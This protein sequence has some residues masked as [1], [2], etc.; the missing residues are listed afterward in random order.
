MPNETIEPAAAP[1]ADPKALLLGIA[2]DRTG[3]PQDMLGLDLNMEADLGI[4]SIKRVEILGAFRKTLPAAVGDALAGRMDD[5]SKAKTLQGILD[6]VASAATA[7]GGAARPFDQAGEGHEQA[8][9][10]LSRSP[11][12]APSDAPA[13]AAAAPLAAPLARYV[14][15]PHAEPLPSGGAGMVPGG[16]YIIV[17]DRLGVAAA[18]GARLE[19]DGARVR[20]VP[21]AVM[22]D[23]D[24]LGKWLGTVRF[25][26]RIRAVVD[27]RPLRRPDPADQADLAAWGRAMTADVKQLFPILRLT[28]PDLMNGGIVLVGSGMGGNFARDVLADPR[29][30][31]LFPGSGGAVGLIKCLSLEWTEC[32]CKAVDLD[33]DLGADQLSEQLHGELA[34]PGGRRDVGYPGG[35]RTVFR[36]EPA[37]LIPQ[38]RPI[39]A[40]DKD[41]VVL[42]IGGARGITAET[43]RPFA[44]AGATC[45][46]VGRSAAAPPAEDPA[47]AALADTPAL[48][49]HFLAEA[50]A[51]GERPRPAA[52]EAKI[53]AVLRDREIRANLDDFR[54]MGAAVDLRACDIRNEAD[55]SAMLHAVY[56]RYGRID[57]VL[58]G[59]GLIEDTLLVNKEMESLSRVFDTKVDGAFVLATR[60][61]PETLKF[62]AFFTSVAGRYGNRGQTDYGAANEVLN[63]Y[64]WL[65][66]A[67][68]GDGVKVTAINWGPWANTT[69]GP[70]MLTPETAK[71]F[72]ERGVSLIGPE[73]GREFLFR[74]LLYAPRDEVEVVAG[75]HPWEYR[76]AEAAR[77]AGEPAP[78]VPVPLLHTAAIV[79]A[80]G[81]GRRYRKSI[82]LVSDPY[83]DEHRL[84]GRPVLPFACAT[85]YMAEAAAMLAGA[86]VRALTGVR[87]LNG[88][89]LRDRPIEVEI[90]CQQSADGATAA[91][92]I[93]T[94]APKPRAAYRAVAEFG[95]IPQAGG[96]ARLGEPVAALP[97]DIDGMYRSW[98]FHGPKFQ[99]V[100]SVLSMGESRIVAHATAS[101][102]GDFYP[103]AQGQDWIF[104]PGL[105]DGAMQLVFAWSRRFRDGACLPT[106][107]GR[108]SRFGDGPLRGDVTLFVN[109]GADETDSLIRWGFEAVD[110]EGR[111]R[112]MVEGGEAWIDP[113]LKRLGGG[114]A[115]GLPLSVEA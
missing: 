115:G 90:A 48:R 78:A 110:P 92:E 45:V 76:E 77:P 31:D 23:E 17:P 53:A 61:R 49:G 19:L 22:N 13:A 50:K 28:A 62:V 35:V 46:I 5:L 65:L 51:A 97:A 64:A 109:V 56:A 25:E 15:R 89:V 2:A 20:I 6:V 105:V 99:T 32:R 66:Q 1:A 68:W 14:I 57:A 95:P 106:G 63:R 67:K 98:L 58:F 102:P 84:D 100:R 87:L 12:S 16:M 111:T 108:V 75:E 52:I 59:A 42:A 43:L 24:L 7:E 81:K 80:N 93:V 70:G 103:P 11:S 88:L 34:Y 96:S 60:L 86:P 21:E 107:I 71:Q 18:L 3:Y 69:R 72:R 10:P 79:P 54:A 38:P 113:Q 83:L 47:L 74:E 44:E 104:D 33:T 30:A 37:S 27:L 41:W 40:P 112:L 29:R 91:M 36:T 101:R 114:W 55:T 85:E 8:S 39:A 26:D 73:E 82:D 4:D 9:A 94:P